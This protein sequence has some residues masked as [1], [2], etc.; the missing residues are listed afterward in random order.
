LKGFLL[1][2]PSFGH[3]LLLLA[4]SFFE[5]VKASLLRVGDLDRAV[6]RHEHGFNGGWF[7]FGGRTDDRDEAR[8]QLQRVLERPLPVVGVAGRRRLRSQ[9]SLNLLSKRVRRRPPN[10]CRLRPE[11]LRI[12]NLAKVLEDAGAGLL[13]DA[14]L[15]SGEQLVLLDV[16]AEH[17]IHLGDDAGQALE[18]RSVALLVQFGLALLTTFVDER[19]RLFTAI[20]EVPRVAH[21]GDEI[22]ETSLRSGALKVNIVEN[23]ASD[24]RIDVEVA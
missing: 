1:L 16:R 9:V 12:G 10:P 18:R 17:R 5:R 4:P 24:P 20:V 15:G 19:K 7:G 22:L 11:V 21:L 8:C 2:T 23:L 13:L 6:D 3:G 14:A